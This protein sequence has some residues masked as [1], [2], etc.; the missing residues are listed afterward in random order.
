MVG[1]KMGITLIEVGGASACCGF[2]AEG[3]ESI[4][5]DLNEVIL[6]RSA[7]EPKPPLFPI[8]MRIIP[9]LHHSNI[10]CCYSI[11]SCG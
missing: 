10:P 1:L 8:F 4:A 11:I 7:P 6:K 9:L 2:V 3:K 5:P